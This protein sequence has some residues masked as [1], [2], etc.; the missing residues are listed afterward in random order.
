[1]KKH[2]STHA[3][4]FL[5]KES[6][7]GL[8][9]IIVVAL[10]FLMSVSPRGKSVTDRFY[11]TIRTTDVRSEAVIVGIDD[12]TLQELGA[13]PFTRTVFADLTRALNEAGARAVVYD[14]LFLE[15][16]DGDDNFKAELESSEIPVILAAKVEGEN[17]LSSYLAEGIE[18]VTSAIANVNPD[19]DGK[20]RRYAT[21]YATPPCVDTL[22]HAAF[23]IY[24]F[25]EG[26]CFTDDALFRY[27]SAIPTYS[28]VDVIRG[29]VATSTLAGKVVFVGSATLDLE[30]HFVGITGS[31]VPG[32]Y[33]HTSM[34]T[35]LLNDV[36]DRHVSSLVSALLLLLCSLGGALSVYRSYRVYSQVGLVLACVLLAI[37]V[38]VLLYSVG[39]IIPLP[40]IIAS[41][42][43]SAGF[44]A[45]VR[46]VTEHKQN[47]YIQS[48]FSKYVHKDVL[49]ELMASGSDLKLGGER[50]VLTILF[51][52]IRGFTTLSESLSPEDLTS[53]LNDYLSAMTPCI[54]EERGTI[55]KFIGD[56]IMAFW[57]APLEIKDH[58][59]HAVKAALRMQRT[60][61]FFNSI[62]NTEL[63]IG[64][65]IHM[66]SAVV[67]NVG[68]KDRVNYTVLGDTVN[69]ASRL[70]GITKKY[71]V[72]II[73]TKPVVDAISDPEISFRC[74][75][76][77]TVVGKSTPTALYEALYTAD[78][79]VGM[80]KKYETAL[81]YYYEGDWDKAET[82]FKK[83]AKEGD[84]PSAKMLERIPLLRKKKDWDGIYRFDEK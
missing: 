17:Y 56:A 30:D 11:D 23:S 57:N 70:E 22:S 19:V 26:R 81:K 6:A 63:A 71:G 3:V 16:R 75:D 72:G 84:K 32:V 65:G 55:D 4:D 83:L 13:W 77:I 40:W 42:V 47:E 15:P 66:G 62:K 29:D 41:I 9:F 51:S 76:V 74:L 12:T 80:I 18:K 27:P 5:K 7:N 24:T 34:F 59:H 69:L 44:I 50:K 58:P 36:R 49:A 82:L 46:F 21:A 1:M 31:K 64:V 54:L 37:V 45:L 43:L 67:G 33:V 48:L 78:I 38:G 14:I 61:L 53:I 25:S 73:V 60:L 52:D 39:Y 10:V 20:V 2:I 68:G 35:S 8:L 79:D 28:L